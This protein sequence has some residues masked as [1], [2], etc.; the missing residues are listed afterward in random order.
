MV[1][2]LVQIRVDEEEFPGADDV[3]GMIDAV[4]PEGM[5]VVSAEVAEEEVE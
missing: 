5:E 4:L 3:I 1:Q 2:Y